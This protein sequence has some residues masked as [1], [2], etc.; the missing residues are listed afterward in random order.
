MHLW[1]VNLPRPLSVVW[2]HCTP[3]SEPN[4]GAHGSGRPGSYE[5][6][7]KVATDE[8]Y[9]D[10]GQEFVRLTMFDA[11]L[12]RWILPWTVGGMRGPTTMLKAPSACCT[13]G[14]ARRV[15]RV[16]HASRHNCTKHRSGRAAH[17]FRLFLLRSIFCWQRARVGK[18]LMSFNKNRSIS[19]VCVGTN[20]HTN[21]R[22]VRFM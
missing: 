19:M 14:S 16:A 13:T 1:R 15:S 9:V 12:R 7:L 6:V 5:H 4:A 18:I 20:N 3:H 17:F 11:W 10:E 21:W 2:H 8:R 22:I